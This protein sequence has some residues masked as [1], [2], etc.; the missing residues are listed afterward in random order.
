MQRASF[1]AVLA[2]LL[3]IR[4]EA[5]SPLRPFPQHT[6]YAAGSVLPSHRTRTQLDEDVRARYDSW[7]S[8]YVMSAG[9]DATGPLY[10]VSFGSTAPHRTVSEGQGFGMVILAMIAGH[11]PEAQKIFD[12]MW[13]FA[14]KYPSSSE[15]RLMAW[16]IPPGDGS[17]A[18]DGDADIAYA[19]LL[20]DAQW[21]SS[22]A[23]HYRCEA[24]R[25]IS[26][27]L[28]ATI[29]PESRLPMLG[30]WVPPRGPRHNQYKVRTSDFMPGNFRAYGR[31]TGDPVWDDV[32]SR[33]QELTDVLQSSY[34]RETG[35]LP[36]FV[37][38]MSAT[39]LRPVP[40]PPHFLEATTDGDYAYN[41][42]RVPWR[43]GIDALLHGDPVSR[44]QA[45]KIAR[46]TRKV[47]GG[48]PRR[49]RAGYRLDGSNLPERDYFTSFFAAPLGVAAMN[50][51]SLQP[52]LNAIYDSV[53]EADEDYYE[54]T[55][56]LLCMFVMT[57][58]AWDPATNRR[59]R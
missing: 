50:D 32:V 52:W 12:G 7:K 11:D 42:G 53:R 38:T 16:E 8:Q 57:G 22:G 55:V 49:L 25:V 41:A 1:V 24:E 18:F 26:G 13:R 46:W 37:V 44:R 29:G 23:I 51:A 33:I 28:D 54:D 4:L 40:A 31:A 58:N 10:R 17:S 6:K 35:L 9:S 14:R 3:V 5:A 15:P 48:N 56:T 21:G 47:T 30:D 27:I 36:D 59:M 43:L 20:A 34:S 45:A 39:D 2:L 19:L